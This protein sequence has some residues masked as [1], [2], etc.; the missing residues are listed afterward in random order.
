MTLGHW[1][2]DGYVGTCINK[3]QLSDPF[4]LSKIKDITLPSESTLNFLSSTLSK[5]KKKI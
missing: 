5:K 4:L 3:F 2:G 1:I